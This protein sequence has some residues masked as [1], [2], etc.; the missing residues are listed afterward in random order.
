MNDNRDFWAF[1]TKIVFKVIP[2]NNTA[3]TALKDNAITAS[4]RIDSKRF[5]ELEENPKYKD[6]L[7]LIRKDIFAYTY[8][9]FNMRKENLKDIR[10]R[11]AIAHA[12]DKE[13]IN[14]VLNNGESTIANSF[15]HPVQTKYLNPDIKPVNLSLIH[16]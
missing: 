3:F 16:I 7:N 4:E 9:G 11:K 8:L 5:K 14:K 2:D 15:I 12:I 6:A 10:V 1:P 13:Q